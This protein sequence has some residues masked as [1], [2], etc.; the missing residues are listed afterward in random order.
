MEASGK[1]TALCVMAATLAFYCLNGG[2]CAHM[3]V[4][5]LTLCGIVATLAIVIRSQ[6]RQDA[7][8]SNGEDESANVLSTSF[9]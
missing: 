2:E 3:G 8:T 9:H 4:Q 1:I 6:H 5:A 7:S